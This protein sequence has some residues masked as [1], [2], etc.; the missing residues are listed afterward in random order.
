MNTTGCYFKVK[1]TLLAV[2]ARINCVSEEA[3]LIPGTIGRAMK[4]LTSKEAAIF[5]APT[6]DPI[7]VR[8]TDVGS[9]VVSAKNLQ[10]N[11]IRL[12]SAEYQAIRRHVHKS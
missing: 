6:E 1:S 7:L 11:S 9:F 4:R 3:K 10:E 5:L 12:S 8:I 2:A